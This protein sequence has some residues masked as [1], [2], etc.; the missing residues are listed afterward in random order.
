MFEEYPEPRCTKDVWVEHG[1]RPETAIENGD[2]THQFLAIPTRTS[3][4]DP[5]LLIEGPVRNPVSPN[6][7]T[8]ENPKP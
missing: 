2:K 6:T 8:T 3:D 7:C 1:L 5:V 4:Q